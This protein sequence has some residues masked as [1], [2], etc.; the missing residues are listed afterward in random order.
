M[1]GSGIFGYKPDSSM[2]KALLLCFF[3]YC[4]ASC[5]TVNIGSNAESYKIQ[6][7]IYPG[8]SYDDA[9]RT[10]VQ[11]AA[12]MRWEIKT[13]NIETGIISATYP[14]TLRR[15][16]DDVNVIISPKDDGVRI[17][18]S[19][20][21]GQESNRIYVAEYLEDIASQLGVATSE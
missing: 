14:Q 3:F 2:N 5:T 15:W 16:S 7:K 10:A 19:S 18:V 12:I 20:N 4:I 21:L 6:V 9:F 1:S 13:R 17:T 8:V 11:V